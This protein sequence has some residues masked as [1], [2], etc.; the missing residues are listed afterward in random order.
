MLC[1]RRCFCLC[2]ELSLLKF[3]KLPLKSWYLFN[4]GFKCTILAFILLNYNYFAPY[5]HRF[6]IIPFLMYSPDNF[7]NVFTPNNQI[8]FFESFLN[9]SQK[10]SSSSLLRI[11]STSILINWLIFNRKPSNS[12][13]KYLPTRLF[14]T[15]YSDDYHFNFESIC[16]HPFRP[17]CK[18]KFCFLSRTWS[19]SARAR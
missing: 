14:R 8:K 11:Y 18:C 6:S 5:F 7:Q 16:S 10:W 9:D 15:N 3:F 12:P 13:W 4:K 17:K 1:I 19:P 2:F